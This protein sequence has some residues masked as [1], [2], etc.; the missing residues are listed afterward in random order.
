[1]DCP[2]P[3]WWLVIQYTAAKQADYI[4]F[5]HR[6]PFA[7]D[8]YELGFA[9]GVREDYS[10]R[11]EQYPN[12][13]L[14]VVIL[15]NDFRDSNLDR[16]LERFERHDPSVAVL[17]D[18]Y[19]AEEAQ[20]LNDAVRQLT[21]D[22]P[23]KEYVVVPKCR[24]AIDVL[25]NEI[26]L[27]YAMGYSDIQAQDIAEYSA[28]RDQK[29]HLLG[30]SPYEQYTVIDRLTQPTLAN[31]PPADIVGLDWNGVQKAA[32]YGKYWHPD[33]WQSADHLSIRETVRTSLH[34]IKRFW[35]DRS[36]WPDTEPIDL[37]GPAVH[38][39]DD[40]VYAVDG[41][42]IRSRD[43]LEES[44]V[45]TYADCTLAYRTE[46]EQAFLEWRDRR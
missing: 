10:Y 8:A 21:D 15:D 39:P 46:T 30:G 26:T 24:T 29:V 43:Q 13:E 34:E 22:Y 25:D 9:P 5:L 6:H 40:P 45:E 1:M 19:T 36:V 32:Y 20:T 14:P 41:A 11:C 23:H 17:G 27:G 35:Q 33:G 38:E 3:V 4:G 7:T 28:W 37:Y 18:A 42:D 44:I 2:A 16:Y 12:V 31:E